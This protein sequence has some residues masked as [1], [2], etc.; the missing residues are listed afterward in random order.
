MK[1]GRKD[2]DNIMLDIELIRLQYEI[3]GCSPALLA[4]VW[5]LPE[6][7]IKEEIDR[8][9]WT[10]LWPDVPVATTLSPASPPPSLDLTVS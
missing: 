6:S 7:L 4:W 3:L 9:N 10:L 8:S 5:E 1:N 2:K